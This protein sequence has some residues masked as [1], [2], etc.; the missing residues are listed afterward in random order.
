[1]FAEWKIIP[2]WKYHVRVQNFFA[3]QKILFNQIQ[4][5]AIVICMLFV[6][7]KEMRSNR[8]MQWN[9]DHTFIHSVNQSAA[10][11]YFVHKFNLM[12]SSILSLRPYDVHCLLCIHLSR[13]GA[14][15]SHQIKYTKRNFI[16]TATWLLVIY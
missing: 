3:T 2:C 8:Q 1:M 5:F 7:P 9:I 12:H 16:A 14:V 10:S 15:K 6:S 11:R 13:I 4:K